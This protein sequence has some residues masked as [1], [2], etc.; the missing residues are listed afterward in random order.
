MGKHEKK[1]RV[2]HQ[3]DEPP[4]ILKIIEGTSL[5]K[6]A[7]KDECDINVIVA[8][9]HRTGILG[10]PLTASSRKPMF[11]DFSTGH[12]FTEAQ[13]AIIDAHEVFQFF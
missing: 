11:G 10:N 7:P 1:K 4:K 5:T 3:L 12:D 6:Q 9:F 8:R 13:N 2:Y